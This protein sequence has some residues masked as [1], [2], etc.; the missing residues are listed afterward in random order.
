MGMDAYI[1][2]GSDLYI[3]ACIS[4]IW[5]SHWGEIVLR[6]QHG[7]LQLCVKIISAGSQKSA[8]L[9]YAPRGKVFKFNERL[10]A[11]SGHYGT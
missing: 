5:P 7:N 6:G 4:C 9:E 11:L 1:V 3:A 8:W 2:H 10:G